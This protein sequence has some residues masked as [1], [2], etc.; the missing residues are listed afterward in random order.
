MAYRHGLTA[1]ICWSFAQHAADAAME[2]ESRVCFDFD[3]KDARPGCG[4]W[5]H[6]DD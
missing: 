2:V 3:G 5:P 4:I 1:D 6:A